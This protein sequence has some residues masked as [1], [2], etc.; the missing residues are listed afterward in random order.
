[1]VGT[2]F[3][4]EAAMR[5][6]IAIILAA[7]LLLGAAPVRA[8]I[9]N[10]SDEYKRSCGNVLNLLPHIVRKS[11]V[12]A[13]RADA[14]VTVH[15]ICAGVQFNDFGNA[16]GLTHTIAANTALVRA[17]WRWGWY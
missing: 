7:G 5:R 16:G 17:L 13:V 2:E 4:Q 6:F 1:M 3:V 15:Q 12:Q 9:W 11:A 14:R 8:Q 10:P